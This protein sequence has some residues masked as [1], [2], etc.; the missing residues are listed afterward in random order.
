MEIGQNTYKLILLDTNVLREIVRNTN[1]AG[2]GFLQ[3]F[4][5]VKISTHHVFLF[6]MHL[7]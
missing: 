3:K 7:N 2:K 4:L 6:I 5:V 1:L